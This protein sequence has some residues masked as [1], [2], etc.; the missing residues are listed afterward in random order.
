MTNKVF[1]R[2]LDVGIEH[3]S[4]A[5]DFNAVHNPN[6]SI[7]QWGINGEV[8]HIRWE[9]YSRAVY[10]V[11]RLVIRKFGTPKRDGEV[12]VILASLGE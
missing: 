10:E 3:L 4:H 2:P 9:Q 5:I 7:F 8:V 12:I 6:H 1:K 11:T